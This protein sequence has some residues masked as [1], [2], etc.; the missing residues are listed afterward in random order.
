V[1]EIAAVLEV[2]AAELEVSTATELAGPL[3]LPLLLEAPGATQLDPVN[4]AAVVGL[5]DA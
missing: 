4:P 1:V 5:V 3:P 2:A